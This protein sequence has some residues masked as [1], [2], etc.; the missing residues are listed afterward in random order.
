MIPRRF[1]K[2]IPKEDEGCVIEVKRTSSGGKRIKIGKNC[3]KQQIDM[4]RESGEIKSDN[5][6]D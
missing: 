3:T 1:I 4:M 6:G 2:P 5:F